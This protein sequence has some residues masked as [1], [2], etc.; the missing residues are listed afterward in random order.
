MN[1]PSQPCETSVQ[2]FKIS[3]LCCFKI[4][5]RVNSESFMLA[6]MSPRSRQSDPMKNFGLSPIFGT[7]CQC[8]RSTL[9]LHHD[10]LSIFRFGSIPLSFF[11]EPK[12]V[13]SDEKL[14]TVSHFLALFAN[15]SDLLFI[16]GMTF[17]PFS[18][19]NPF[20]YRSFSNPKKSDPMRNFELSPIFWHFLPMPQIYS[21]SLGWHFVHFWVR[22]HSFIVLSWTQNKW[23]KS[24]LHSCR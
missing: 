24:Q 16:L 5:A 12:T 19:S 18:G 15:V 6:I 17:C 2:F 1:I 23:S 22:I 13:R 7:F 8:L 14:G 4:W 10:I 20:L 11:L 9:H 21:S 3:V